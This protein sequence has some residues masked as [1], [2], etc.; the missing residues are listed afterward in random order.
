MGLEG[1]ESGF[2]TDCYDVDDGRFLGVCCCG[3]LFL[4]FFWRY[5]FSSRP[6]LND[7]STLTS[8]LFVLCSV[9]IMIIAA[10]RSGKVMCRARDAVVIC[11]GGGARG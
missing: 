4:S 1:L 2:R 5:G 6:F 9:H 8:T 11:D 7:E 10:L 3:P